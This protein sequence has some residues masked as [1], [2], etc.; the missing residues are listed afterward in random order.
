MLVTVTDDRVE[1][2]TLGEINHVILLTYGRHQ[3]GQVG[4]VHLRVVLIGFR[5]IP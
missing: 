3:S 5:F 2:Q 1:H 4:I